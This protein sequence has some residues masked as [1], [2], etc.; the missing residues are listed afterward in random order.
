MMNVAASRSQEDAVLVDTLVENKLSRVLIW[1]DINKWKSQSIAD[2][3]DDE[4]SVL[5]QGQTFIV[6][7]FASNDYFAWN[8]R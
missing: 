6:D 2:L 5:L 1:F 8:F 7:F 4:I 3:P